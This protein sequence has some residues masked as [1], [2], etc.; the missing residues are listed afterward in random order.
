MAF[1]EIA[2]AD[3][4]GSIRL[5]LGLASSD[6]TTLP[7]AT[8]ASRLFGPWVERR[9]QQLVDEGVELRCGVDV[10]GT[11]RGHLGEHRL[12]RRI[13]RLEIFGAGHRL[14]RRTRGPAGG[15]TRAGQWR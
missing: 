2:S 6:T 13:Q 3:D 4:Y 1:P 9:V 7:D 5:A 11:A 15:A 8:I 12:A 14:A 10:V